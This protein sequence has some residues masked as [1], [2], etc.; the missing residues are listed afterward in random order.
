MKSAQ[1]ATAAFKKLFEAAH[2][3]PANAPRIHFLVP[4]EE[5]RKSPIFINYNIPGTETGTYQMQNESSIAVNPL[6]PKNMI[7]AAVDYRDNSATW[8]YVSSDA[9]RSWTNLNLGHPFPTWTS[10]NDPSVAYDAD[11]VGYLVVGGFG[12]RFDSLGQSYGENGVFLART[13]DEGKTWEAHIPVILHQMPQTVD[14][15]FEDKY[16]I[17]ADNSPQS[18]YYKNLYIPWKRVMINDTST[19]IVITKSTDKGSTWSVPTPVSYRLSRSSEDTTF[20]Q[21]FPLCTTGPNGEVYLVWNHGIE[22]GVGFS[23]SFDGGITWSEPKIIQRYNIFG[24]TKLLAEGWRHTVKEIVRAEAYPVIVCDITNSERRGWLYLCWSA[25]SIP[26]VY[27]SRSTDNGDTWSQPKIVHSTT[28]NDQFWH[29]MAL[30]PINGDLGIMFLDSRN[31]PNNILVEC[32]ASYSSD[33]GDT[34]TDRLVSD[35]GMDLR[36][37]PFQGNNF[38]GDYSGCAFYDGVIYPSWVDMR[39]AAQNI[40]DS[41]VFTAYVNTKAPVPP[42]NFVAKSIPDDKNKIRLTW[43]APTESSFGRTIDVPAMKYALLR[44]GSVIGV[45]NS[46]VTEYFDEGLTAHEKYTYSIYAWIGGDTSK[47]VVSSAFA[48]GGKNPS[49]ASI[50]DKQFIGNK[51]LNLK[52]QL[53][54]TREDGATVLLNM[55][56]VEIWRDSAYYKTI[57]VATGDT[58]KIIVFID[59]VPAAGYYRYSV[60]VLDNSIPTGKSAS[61]NEVIVYAG[62]AEP[63]YTEN[64]DG[65]Q[66]AKYLVYGTWGLCPTFYLSPDNSLTDSP[67]GNYQALENYSIQLFPVKLDNVH[68]TKLSFWHAAIV[69]KGDSA[70]VEYRLGESGQWLSLAFYNKTLFEPWNNEALA[71]DDWKY[72]EF[73]FE[74]LSDTLFVRFRL[75]TNVTV[76]NDGWFIDN[77]KFDMVTPVQEEYSESADYMLFPIPASD[78]VTLYFNRLDNKINSKIILV[79]ELGEKVKE[80]SVETNQGFYTMPLQNLNTGIYSL[81]LFSNDELLINKMLSVVK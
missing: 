1:Q 41:E 50:V 26:N 49:P 18:P 62:D 32:F 57:D 24:K 70:I 14:S 45:F 27:F 29:W 5:Y 76:Q 19:Q 7:S 61:S 34:W 20:G 31:D 55:A 74:H 75:K 11:G 69:A 59:D 40:Y 16:Y 52:I 71:S 23:R 42:Q 4:E 21:S 53:P 13:F 28:Q 46:N 68:A 67:S 77:V 36:Y 33:G 65:N 44:N 56:K 72:E 6:N 2:P 15:A 17:Q 9:G 35:Q 63:Y 64:F 47:T 60:Y 10:S 54:T 25:D 12:L 43:D 3:S 37:N 79:N 80:C 48:G 78:Y 22:H 81:M 38:A 39:F 30:D 8:V 51:Q 73:I 58:G 66:L